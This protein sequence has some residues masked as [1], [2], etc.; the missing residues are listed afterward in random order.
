MVEDMAALGPDAPTLCEGWDTRDL[1]AHLLLRE[2][3][4][5]AMVG[6]LVSAFSTHTDKVQDQIAAGDW[7][8]LLDDLRSGPPAWSPARFEKIDRAMNTHEFF[9][10]RE[11]V[12]RAQP[13]WAPRDLDPELVEDL[14]TALRRSAKLLAR[15]S[16][17]GIVLAPDGQDEITAKD[18][19][20]S[21]T[22]RGPI[23]EIVLFLFGR[24]E[25][26][27][28]EIDGA[29]DDV[30]AARSTEFGF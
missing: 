10:H 6:V 2:R 17:V 29:P 14:H 25:H 18:A 13:G 5:D 1:T 20:P 21:V 30:A 23:G 28:V 16:S 19:T 15:S 24:G 7:D 12:L 4:P 22:V 11:D 27:R 8:D 3:R 9:V 26:A